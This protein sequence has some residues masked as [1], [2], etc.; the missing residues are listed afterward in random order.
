MLMQGRAMVRTWVL[1][2]LQR[3][4]RHLSRFDRQFRQPRIWS[5]RE[6][7]LLGPLFEGDVINVSGWKDEDK[8]GRHY[9]DYFPHARSY[10]VSNHS[11]ARGATSASDEVILD[12][13]GPLPQALHLR[14]DLVF[15]H[16]TLEHIYELRCAFANLCSMSRDAVI[17]VVPF[18]QPHHP[19]GS[20][21]DYWRF[22]PESVMKLFEENGFH[23]VYVRASALRA[24][25]VYVIAVAVR[26]PD[27]WRD[28]MPEPPSVGTGAA[29]DAAVPNWRVFKWVDQWILRLIRPANGVKP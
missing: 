24:A 11:G 15:N 22:S 19:G 27:R 21:G 25:S 18:V 6:L 13:E 1:R 5:N 26:E 28:R 16:T 12:L 7:S 8:A 3:L 10:V 9:R 14:F 20:Y 23:C 17:V 2:G 29:G 4:R